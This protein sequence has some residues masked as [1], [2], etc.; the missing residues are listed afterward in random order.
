MIACTV[1]LTSILLYF[2]ALLGVET[3]AAFTL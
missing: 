1:V 2:F 3:F